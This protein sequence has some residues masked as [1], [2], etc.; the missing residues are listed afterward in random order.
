MD[1][2][3]TS[4]I[5]AIVTGIFGAITG[6]I[7]L[8]LSIRELHISKPKLNVLIDQCT[9]YVDREIFRD[10]ESESEGHTMFNVWLKISNTGKE[11]IEISEPKYH[12]DS[13]IIGSHFSNVVGGVIDEK[14]IMKSVQISG[15]GFKYLY[16]KFIV[17]FEIMNDTNAFFEYK[18]G[19]GKKH[20]QEVKSDW[21]NYVK[22]I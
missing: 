10:P 6:A 12:V 22:S 2:N 11:T 15:R 17:P 9:H 4:I 8:I 21:L 13:W 7:S 3:Q 5:I 1:I 19:N 18:D 16:I 20:R 14:N